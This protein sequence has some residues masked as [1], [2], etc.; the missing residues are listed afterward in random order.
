[1][2]VR[3]IVCPVSAFSAASFAAL[4]EIDPHWVLLFADIS[5]FDDDLYGRLRTAFPAARLSGCSTAG[6]I[7]G[8]RVQDETVVLT[9]VRFGGAQPQVAVVHLANMADSEAAGARL[10]A[11]LDPEDLGSV[12]VLAQGININGSALIR[13]LAAGLPKGISIWGGL[14]ADGGAFK[15]TFVLTDFGVSDTAV[16][17]LGF[18]KDE[19]V[20]GHGGFGGWQVFGPIR[21]VTRCEENVLFEL[22]GEPALD[23][24]QRYLGEYASE[25]PASGLLFPFSMLDAARGN[26]GLIRTILGVDAARGALILAGEIATDGYMQ[27]MH[28]SADALVDGAAT[29]ADMARRGM[30]GGGGGLVVLVSCV[31]RKLVMGDRV[32]EE[33]E[34]VAQVFGQDCVVCGFYSNGEISPFLGTTE[35]KLHNQT[36]TVTCLS[37]RR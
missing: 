28:A 19:V 36:M 32:D 30:A 29:A 23:I 5:A 34:A 18:R 2:Q 17:A 21:R 3:Q 16:V 6:E 8:D 31:G 7:A 1:M 13:G 37:P 11:Q 14:A 25:L 27:M 33:V 12:M 9:A 15:R 20:T 24:Y 35:C 26:V 22:D 4:Q 10:A